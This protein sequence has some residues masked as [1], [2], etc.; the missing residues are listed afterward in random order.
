MTV[1][2]IDGLPESEQQPQ[3]RAAE[4]GRGTAINH[5]I[6]DRAAAEA[7][8]QIAAGCL[9]SFT[10]G[11][12]E[13]CCKCDDHGVGPVEILRI[14]G[15]HELVL[16]SFSAASLNTALSEKRLVRRPVF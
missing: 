11:A 6:P 16:R 9:E 12:T 7:V 1:V 13:I 10:S 4:A 3:S 15:N 14:A 2:A 8:L 5:D